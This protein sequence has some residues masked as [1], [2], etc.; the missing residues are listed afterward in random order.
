MIEQLNRIRR[1][2]VSVVCLT[3]VLG[4]CSC[5]DLGL[6]VPG[7]TDNETADYQAV[8]ANVE[9]AVPTE[10]DLTDEAQY[11]FFVRQM[12]LSGFTADN[13]SELFTALELS[14][15]SSAN[16][17]NG[18]SG[19]NGSNTVNETPTFSISKFET[20][21]GMNYTAAAEANLPVP[22]QVLTLTLELYDENTCRIF[23]LDTEQKYNCSGTITITTTGRSSLFSIPGKN[24]TAL[25]IWTY[26]SLSDGSP[27]TG[28]VRST[29]TFQ[30]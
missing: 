2:M 23:S 8:L 1:F 12:Q 16:G 3:G 20:S 9:E 22:V 21:D 28:L 14:L 13:S 6:E 7:L 15:L 17:S 30:P 25:L 18:L 4:L 5:G 27:S 29:V 24:I 10:M 19:L 26:V 11:R